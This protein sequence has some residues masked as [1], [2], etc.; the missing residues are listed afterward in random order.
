MTDSYNIYDKKNNLVFQGTLLE[1]ALITNVSKE[2]LI[3]ACNAMSLVNK[4]YYITT[5]EE[6]KEYEE[7]REKKRKERK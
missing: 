1:C 4:K 2:S 5:T 7:Y 6:M 3:V